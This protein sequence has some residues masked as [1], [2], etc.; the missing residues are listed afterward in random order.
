MIREPGDNQDR[1]PLMVSVKPALDLAAVRCWGAVPVMPSSVVSPM[2]CLKEVATAMAFIEP[3]H[4]ACPGSKCLAQVVNRI[5][6]QPGN[7]GGVAAGGGEGFSTSRGTVHADRSWLKML[8]KVG[9][10]IVH[11]RGFGF[12]CTGTGLGRIAEVFGGVAGF[13]GQAPGSS[14]TSGTCFPC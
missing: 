2:R 8:T 3:R 4:P 7:V 11:T 9:V 1:T 5:P 14:P 10:H 12:G 6:V 13:Q